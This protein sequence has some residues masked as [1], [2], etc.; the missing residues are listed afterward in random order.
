MGG[1]RRPA[2]GKPGSW[3][4]HD[5][6]QCW[7]E[8]DCRRC[9]PMSASSTHWPAVLLDAARDCACRPGTSPGHACVCPALG[10]SRWQRTRTLPPAFA[11]RPLV[12]SRRRSAPS[13]RDHAACGPRAARL[14]AAIGHCPCA[15][16]RGRR[17]PIPEVQWDRRLALL[18]GFQPQS[19][20]RGGDDPSTCRSLGHVSGAGRAPCRPWVLRSRCGSR[21]V[22]RS[23]R[24]ARA[25]HAIG[26]AQVM[27]PARAMSGGPRGRQAPLT[28]SAWAL[29]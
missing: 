15:H 22:M 7:N 25:A 28:V 16:R 1:G 18:G 20:D 27:R 4:G 5:A 13:A 12:P 8:L 11:L 10:L 24:A 2:L 6:S 17:V 21:V 3:R 19:L 23:A 29:G 9:V 14:L 26:P